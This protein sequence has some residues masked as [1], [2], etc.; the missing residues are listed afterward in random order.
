MENFVNSDQ[1]GAARH[2]KALLRKAKKIQKNAIAARSATVAASV[3]SST[4]AAG[5]TSVKTP[6]KDE[7]KIKK[8]KDKSKDSSPMLEG[9]VKKRKK[10]KADS[11]LS[12][13]A[14][15]QSQ[16]QNEI[17]SALTSQQRMRK[18]STKTGDPNKPRGKG[19]RGPYN[20]RPKIDSDGNLLIKDK[21]KGW[22]IV[23]KVG[24]D[25]AAQEEGRRQ[26]DM[27][28]EDNDSGEDS[29]QGDEAGRGKRQAVA[30][31]IVEQRLP[32]PPTPEPHEAKKSN[33]K[34]S[35]ASGQS[36]AREVLRG[37]E[38][39]GLRIAKTSAGERSS[40]G[41]VDAKLSSLLKSNNMRKDDSSSLS[42]P[43]GVAAPDETG[44]PGTQGDMPDSRERGVLA[45]SDRETKQGEETGAEGG[46]N[47]KEGSS[48][49]PQAG[50]NGKYGGGETDK[51][52]DSPS[53]HFAPRTKKSKNK[54]SKMKKKEE[55][56]KQKAKTDRDGATLIKARAE[57]IVGKAQTCNV[58]GDAAYISGGDGAAVTAKPDNESHKHSLSKP[59]EDEEKAQVLN[60]GSTAGSSLERR[61]RDGSSPH[62]RKEEA[63]PGRG[64][65]LSADDGLGELPPE[66]EHK[67]R[68]SSSGQRVA[69]TNKRAKRGS[70][71]DMVRR[72]EAVVPEEGKAAEESPLTTRVSKKRRESAVV[73]AARLSGKNC[74]TDDPN[75]EVQ[76]HQAGEGDED[77]DVEGNTAK[78]AEEIRPRLKRQCNQEKEKKS[79]QAKA[80]GRSPVS[81]GR[82][83][84]GSGDVQ[85]DETNDEADP[86]PLLSHS[87]RRRKAA[88]FS[89]GSRA[90]SRESAGTEG[91]SVSS[92]RRSVG[93]STSGGGKRAVGERSKDG[94]RDSAPSLRQSSRAASAAASA[95]LTEVF[96]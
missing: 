54:A 68:A 14:E 24:A 94:G 10:T 57:A 83:G 69:K 95:A 51:I 76:D 21:L 48:L 42:S 7:A 11:S 66:E 3:K 56:R 13:G 22:I 88:S 65:S 75:T 33:V 93:A 12:P 16:D 78:E 31:Q 36:V 39:T 60:A 34:P 61:A 28:G 53:K 72:E 64:S 15:K 29:A 63:R 26:K 77:G 32:Q 17:G 30:Q 6:S 9:Q 50:G 87:K 85:D 73:A 8:R 82:L 71:D 90:S 74:K 37:H 5:T 52:D 79:R 84:R 38:G 19:S 55:R 70:G 45:A 1:P 58:D 80:G 89:G 62:M 92:R 4:K 43:Q 40:R 35:G 47:G 23:G 46:G 2:R 67:K 59:G 27:A 81:G 20:K 18:K 91:G 44:E 49:L 96:S 41:D 25:R 86:E